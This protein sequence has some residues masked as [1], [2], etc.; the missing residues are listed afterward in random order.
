MPF[1]TFESKF[2]DIDSIIF[3]III[4]FPIIGVIICCMD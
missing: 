1:S 2:D 3:W 4:L